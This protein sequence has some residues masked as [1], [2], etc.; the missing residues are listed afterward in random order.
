MENLTTNNTMDNQQLEEI[1]Q[2]LQS[3]TNKQQII[4]KTLKENEYNSEQLMLKI[5][6]EQLQNQDI[7]IIMES[8]TIEKEIDTILS[9]LGYNQEEQNQIRRKYNQIIMEENEQQTKV[10][11]DLNKKRKRNNKDNEEEEQPKH[12]EKLIEL[13]KEQTEQNEQI[14]KLM[15]ESLMIAK[16]T[17]KYLNYLYTEKS[18]KK[19]RR[20]MEENTEQ[21]KTT[22]KRKNVTPMQIRYQERRKTEIREEE[23]LR[24]RMKD[25]E[26]SGYFDKH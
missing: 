8:T 7:K 2:R 9:L 13:I 4:T 25:L 6:V 19:R 14:I 11:P 5:P 18:D 20:L 17:K 26:N 3:N 23:S 22:R 1:L 15:R 16:D 21:S 10:T 12:M 24:K